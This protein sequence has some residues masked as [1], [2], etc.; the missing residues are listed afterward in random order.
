M[1]TDWKARARIAERDVRALMAWLHKANWEVISDLQYSDE[2]EIRENPHLQHLNTLSRRID[3][4]LEKMK[5][6]YGR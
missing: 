5:A 3:K 6:R 1:S 2:K 4:V